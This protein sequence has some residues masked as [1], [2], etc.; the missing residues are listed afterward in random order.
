MSV[1]TEGITSEE[2][3]S[4]EEHQPDPGRLVEMLK[5]KGWVEIAN[6]MGVSR[7]LPGLWSLPEIHSFQGI[8]LK[9]GP[10]TEGFLFVGYEQLDAFDTDQR[11][12]AR[13][14]AGFAALCLQRARS[15]YLSETQ[16]PQGERLKALLSAFYQTSGII[17]SASGGFPSSRILDEIL[18]Q[19]VECTRIGK[20]EQRNTIGSI[21]LFD[22]T[23]NN[24]KLES[25]Y[26]LGIQTGRVAG[27]TTAV[28]AEFNR[29]GVIGRA[30]L[31]K[32]PQNVGN[33]VGDDDY[34]TCDPETISE[35]AVPILES[36]IVLGVLN[37]ECDKPNAFDDVDV[38]TL[39][40]LASLATIAIQNAREA[41][42][43]SLLLRT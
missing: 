8:A 6:M 42:R 20:D 18:R 31:K 32:E 22:R 13:K 30:V 15:G 11:Q 4:I 12:R 25:L 2:W 28:I 38:M 41:E 14:F 3:L 37:L 19:A 35:I 17:T 40:A 39:S 27:D 10:K 16:A 26:P 23:S 9:V 36:G 24:L 5:I 21:E 33:V 43:D 1:F 7:V 34:I 29:I